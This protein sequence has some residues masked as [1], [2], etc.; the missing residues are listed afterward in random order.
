MKIEYVFK[1]S[2]YDES[3]REQ[4]ARALNKKAEI[5][6]RDK[7]P[8][9]WSM[10]DLLNSHRAD[11][12]TLKKRKIRYRIYGIILILLGIFL[13]VPGIMSPKTMM[14]PLLVGAVGIIA[15]ISY[16][17]PRKTAPSKKIYAAADELIGKLKA[18]DTEGFEIKFTAKDGMLIG[19]DIIEYSKFNAL[20]ETDDL[21]VMTWNDKV[22]ILKKSDLTEGD[23]EE[24]PYHLKNSTKLMMER[25]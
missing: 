18:I 11:E 22:T 20:V 14:T 6:S 15:G 4:I 17:K 21:Y 7:Y 10:I 25:V 16:I 19:D 5:I 24:F 1:L 23:P 2:K 12:N 13:F 3:L 9:L 8:G